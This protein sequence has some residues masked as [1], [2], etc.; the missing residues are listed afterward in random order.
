MKAILV[1]EDGFCLEGDSFTGTIEFTSG[2]ITCN[3]TMGAYQEMLT[4]PAYAGQLLCMTWPLVGNYGINN[5]DKESNAIHANALIV[6][7]CCNHP[8]NWRSVMSL[9]EFMTKNKKPGIENIDTRA[10]MVHVREHGSMKA[11][12]STEILDQ[13]AL[14]QKLKNTTLQKYPIESIATKKPYSWENNAPKTIDLNN[15]QW[16]SKNPHMVIYDFGTKFSTLRAI[17]QHNIEILI[18][19]PNTSLQILEN[20]KPDAILFSEGVG[21]PALCKNEIALVKNVVE[22]NPCTIVATGLGFQIL[23]I[24]L[25]ASTK[26]L[27]N[28]KHGSN[29][30]VKILANNRVHIAN[31]NQKFHVEANKN[32]TPT[33]IAMS[34]KTLQGF[35][36]KNIYAIQHDITNALSYTGENTFL[37]EIYSVIRNN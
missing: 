29:I 3:T 19:P 14:L 35:K 24:A 16:K 8:S 17:T 36:T 9:A 12:I 27:K 1:L 28:G 37:D 6:K 7:E 26:L 15:Y 2:E 34:D 21:D 33:H 22:K 5:E 25:G 10:L 18:V 11:A 32:I 23:A 13:N 4:D 30:P 31:I 20:L